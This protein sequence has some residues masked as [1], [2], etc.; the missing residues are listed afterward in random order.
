MTRSVRHLAVLSASVLVAAAA[1]SLA[2]T[3]VA[4]PGGRGHGHGHPELAWQPV[5]VSTGQN[6][7]G[8]DAVDRRTAWV[9]GSAGGVWRTD[10]GGRTWQDVSPP[11]AAGLEF[12]DIE[13]HGRRTVSALA[14]GVGDQNQIY[15]TT[16]RGRSWT[17]TFVS[18]EPAS[19]YDCMAFYPGGRVGLAV[20]DPFDGHLRII[21]TTD[22]GATWQ[23]LPTDGFPDPAAGEFYF[24]AS[25]TCL[26]T[27]GTQAYL[28]SGG[29]AA[30]ILHSG[31][32]GLTWDV[33]ESNLP[34]GDAA[35]VFSLA[36]RTPYSGVAVGGDF[37]DETNGTDFAATTRDGATWTGGSDLGGYR[38]GV[39]WLQRRPRSAVAVGPTG[40]DLSHDGG[41]TWVTVDDVRYDAVQCTPDGACWASGPAGTVARFAP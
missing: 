17:R 31:D 27:A 34:S 8:L 23:V 37:L 29:G 33:A 3:S 11:E 35:G 4:A 1:L 20:S 12:R 36:F 16:D 26:V 39:A 40:T 10:D 38:S 30:R 9:A 18:D 6:F 41:R 24:A 14:I 25:G 28:G 22:A 19:F 2:S 15:R 21:R 5:P 32:F 7:R 13:V